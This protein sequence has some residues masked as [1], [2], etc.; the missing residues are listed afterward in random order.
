A[1]IY[2]NNFAG[3]VWAHTYIEWWQ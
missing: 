3:E 1:T 2:E